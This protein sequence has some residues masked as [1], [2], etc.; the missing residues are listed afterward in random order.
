MSS[1]LAA[2]E[3]YAGGGYIGIVDKSSVDSEQVDVGREHRSPSQPIVEGSD[4]CRDG[5]SEQKGGGNSLEL[6]KS[7]ESTARL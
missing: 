2:T 5:A 6:L 1:Q 3:L 4:G 7:P